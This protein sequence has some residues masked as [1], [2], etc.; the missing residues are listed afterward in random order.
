[1]GSRDRRVLIC[2]AAIRVLAGTGARGLTHRAVDLEADLPIGSTSYYARTRQALLDLVADR[3]VE[4]DLEDVGTPSAPGGD[5]AALLRVWSAPDR[6]AQVLAR[7]ELFLESARNPAVADRLR[8]PRERFAQVCQAALERA[9][10]APSPQAG[11]LLTAAVEGLLLNEVMGISDSVLP[12][13]EAV[14]RTFSHRS[15]TRGL[16]DKRT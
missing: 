2:D 8:G 16:V 3:L 12:A 11:L 9:D 13:L 4:I 5:L 1:M 15:E 10:L 14:V 6:R 7:Y